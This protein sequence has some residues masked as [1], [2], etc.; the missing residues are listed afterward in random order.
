MKRI[1]FLCTGNSCRSQMAEGWA[2]HLKGDRVEAHSAGIETHGLNPNAVEMMAEAGVDISTHRS[3]HIDEF[4]EV[5][6][7]YV[8]TVC[9]HADEHCPIFPGDTQVIHHPFDDPPRLAKEAKSE[10]EALGHYRRVRDEI[11]A[12]VDTLPESLEN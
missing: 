2:H 8:I 5:A 6:L 10:E 11:R 3:Q 7:D 4:S 9:G 12:F 1:L